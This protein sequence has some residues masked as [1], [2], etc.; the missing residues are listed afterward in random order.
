MLCNAHNTGT[1]LVQGTGDGVA[2]GLANGGMELR[3][4]E[5]GEEGS[6]GGLGEH[7]DGG[8]MVLVDYAWSEG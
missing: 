3:S 1:Y 2:I 6:D 5:A 4:G 8:G 7:G